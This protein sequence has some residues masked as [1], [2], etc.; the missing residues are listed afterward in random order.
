MASGM[1]ATSDIK[2]GSLGGLGKTV[3]ITFAN[4][5]CC[6]VMGLRIPNVSFCKLYETWNGTPITILESIPETFTITKSSN[7]HEI[8][9]T[10]NTT[11][12]VPFIA[13]GASSLSYS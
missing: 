11:G 5:N 9:M 4:T 12:A 7:S 10:N 8:T 13:I 2:I 3:T 1:I 6:L